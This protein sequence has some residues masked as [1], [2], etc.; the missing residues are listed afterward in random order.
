MGAYIAAFVGSLAFAGV[1][2]TDKMMAGSTY[3]RPM[4][5]LAVSAVLNFAWAWS[6]FLFLDYH[7]PPPEAIW[8]AIIAGVVMT[9]YNAISFIAIFSPHGEATEVSAWDA[10]S[11]V[12]FRLMAPI[13]SVTDAIT[14]IQVVGIFLVPLSLF[15]LRVWGDQLTTLPWKFRLLLIAFSFVGGLHIWIADRCVAL[16]M[17]DSVDARTAFASVSPFYWAGNLAGVLPILV[18]KNE[19]KAFSSQFYVL[20]VA[21][22]KL[23]V[24]EFFGMLG[25]STQLYGF[26]GG[27]PAVINTLVS[28]FP[29]W[30]FF[31]GMFLRCLGYKEVFQ[32]VRH[33]I[34]KTIVVCLLVLATSLAVSGSSLQFLFE[35]L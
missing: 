33:P 35:D 24:V 12:A 17:S 31:G 6:V 9:I 21:W 26:S 22:R 16:A 32:A 5:P 29:L 28:S 19:R 1:I 25:Y 18:L 15:L 13:L 4:Q 2:L 14:D 11:S 30:I 8:T 34:K 3:N 27:H 10:S 20:R 7:Q 23:L